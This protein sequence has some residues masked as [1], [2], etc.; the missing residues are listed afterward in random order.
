MHNMIQIKGA[1]DGLRILFDDSAEWPDLL[2]ELR[3]QLMQGGN[4]FAGA[5]LTLDVGERALSDE[6]LSAVLAIMEEHGLQTEAV[7]TSASATR[8]L[9]RAAGL[10]ARSTPRPATAAQALPSLDEAMLLVRT[11]RSG[12]VIR[13]Q[14]HVALIGDVN[15]GAEIIAGGSVVVWGRLRGMVHAGALGDSSAMIC[16]LEL[17]PTQLRIAHLIARTPEDGNDR[18]TVQPE[19]ARVV[20][21]Q[22]VVESWDFPRH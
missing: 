7:S 4:F 5:K 16:A 15:P 21:A 8:R 2:T 12:Q 3:T 6:Q 22:I 9:A 18:Y 19:V 10:T 13:H 20:Q 1:R 17:R 14:G 11:V